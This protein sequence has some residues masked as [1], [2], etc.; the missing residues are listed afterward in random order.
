MKLKIISPVLL[1]LA[2][3][4][5]CTSG[6]TADSL[7]PLFTDQDAVF[8]PALMGHWETPDQDGKSDGG[9]EFLKA[10]EN[11]YRII[12]TNNDGDAAE[13]EAHLVILQGR[14]FLDVVPGSVPK[15]WA[16]LPDTDVVMADSPNAANGPS[17]KP[18]FR[19]PLVRLGG[20]E[21]LEFAGGDSA[22]QSGHFKLRVRL[23]HWFC[24][25]SME[26]PSLRLDCLDSDWLGEQ[27]EEGKTNIEHVSVAA[28]HDGYVLTATTADLQQFVLA[29]ADDEK[30]FSWSMIARRIQ[31]KDS[32]LT[33]GAQ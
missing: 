7:N 29:H 17:D 30:A 20:P 23:G 2:I 4:A 16:G 11:G 31:K 26:G 10:G 8:D 28:G 27:I 13:Y 1:L 22:A 25:M 33:E 3:L 18:K 5:G 14:R 32:N 21:Y 12:M 6:N 15:E 19:P 24:K 9:L